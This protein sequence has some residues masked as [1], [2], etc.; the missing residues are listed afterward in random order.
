MQRGLE[1]YG[2]DLVFSIG[3][4]CECMLYLPKYFHKLYLLDFP[5]QF[6]KNAINFCCL[7][8]KYHFISGFESLI[9]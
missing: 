6:S 2:Y 5:S 3:G 4:G 8:R 7:G 1:R 9:M